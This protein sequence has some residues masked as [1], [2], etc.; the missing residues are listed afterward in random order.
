MLVVLDCMSFCRI[1]AKGAIP[2]GYQ[3]ACST[4]LHLSVHP[5]PT[6][7]TSERASLGRI[8]QLQHL[9]VQ[10]RGPSSLRYPST[11]WS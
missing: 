6:H 11:P 2:R 7:F 8:R 5:N 3:R 4:Y 10:G 1:R 9:H